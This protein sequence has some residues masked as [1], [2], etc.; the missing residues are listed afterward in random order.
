[1]DERAR[2]IEN[3]LDSFGVPVRVVG[4]QTGPTVTQFALEPGAVER[5]MTDGTTKKVKIISTG[6]YSSPSWSPDGKSLVVMESFGDAYDPNNLPGDR[7]VIIDM[8]S[9]WNLFDK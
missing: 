1:M 6:L 9:L 4:T 5:R 2:I 3:T 8:T 7:I